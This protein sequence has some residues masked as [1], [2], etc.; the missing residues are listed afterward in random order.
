MK[1]MFF[2][3]IILL[4]MNKKPYEKS[5]ELYNLGH[6]SEAI[7]CLEIFLERDEPQNAKA[8]KLLGELNAEND[9][10][11]KAI[12]ALN[13]STE[14]DPTDIEALMQLSVSHANNY[15]LESVIQVLRQWLFQ[16][17]KYESLSQDMV[18]L[19]DDIDICL[20]DTI[21]IFINAVQLNI[22]DPDVYSAL[23]VLYNC[24]FD[25]QKA[26]ECFKESLKRNPNDYRLWN[27]LGAT[28]ANA[29][30]P[31]EAIISYTESLNVNPNFTRAR[32]NLG[33]SLMSL[34]QFEEAAKCFLGAISINNNAKHLWKSL[35][36]CFFLM[37]NKD[38]VDLC[39]N[40]NIDD[41]RLIYDF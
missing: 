10:D 32:S 24:N 20:E 6:I 22:N 38:L 33:V 25:Y 18:P 12:Q 39:E 21:N 35:R 1:I 23:G 37:K 3:R 4:V 15:N 17:N 29:S 40:M 19:N 8:W 34:E 16:N 13:K 7:L 26:I 36:N 5:L 27:K 41:F 31:E 28:Q 2:H 9:N 11:T 14:L 30:F